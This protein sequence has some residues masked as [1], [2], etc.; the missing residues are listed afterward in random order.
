MSNE[1]RSFIGEITD[2]VQPLHHAYTTAM[3]TAAITGK[4]DDNDA[5]KRAQADLM[6]YWADPDRFEI[7]RCLRVIHLSAAKAQ[8]D[9]ATIERLTELEAEVR[10]IYYNFRGEVDGNTLSDNEL[11]QLLIETHDSDEA[12]AAWR[13]SKQVGAEVA[14]SVRQLAHTR[15]QAAHAAGYRD[16]YARSLALNEIDEDELFQLLD[17]L[18]L[19]TN[20]S[21]LE[22]KN[23]IDDQRAER[24]GVEPEDLRPWHYGDR[25]FQRVP[26]LDDVDL[27]ASY[28]GR[29]PVELALS[30]YT[31]WGLDIQDVLDRSDLYARRGKNQHAFCLDLDRQGDVRTL[32]N[33]EPNRRWIGTLHHELGHAMY[34]KLIDRDLPWLLRK[35]PHTLSTEAVALLMESALSE[36]DWLTSVLGVDPEDAERLAVAA[37]DRRR[38]QDLV[39]TRWALV[40]THFEQSL[41][42]DPDQDLDGLWWTLKSRYQRIRCPADR[43]APDWAAKYHLAL[44]PVYY[45][46]YEL[47]LLFTYQIKRA[48]LSDLGSWI[49]N[50]RVGPWLTEHVFQSGAAN[51][52]Q[53]HIRVATGEPLDN[54]YFTGQASD[55]V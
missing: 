21:Y 2:R 29:D 17:K 14:D 5:E 11:D 49:G 19:A 34:D 26:E 40:M 31:G 6:R 36:H 47:G 20:R 3:W 48:M 51:P 32:N 18:E 25:F 41:Y 43:Q 1:A 33:L 16:H 45:Q 10:R 54:G 22:L 13:A 38:A 42:E 52:W 35:P 46:N 7:A 12:H 30:S 24:F 50:E 55:G 44:A 53:E 37:A 27:D 28:G 9:E 8:Q 39:F 15:N 4:P 23:R